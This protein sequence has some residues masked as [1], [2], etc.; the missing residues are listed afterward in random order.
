[1]ILL[2]VL[3]HNTVDLLLA[4]IHHNTDTF[5]IFLTIV[6]MNFTAFFRWAQIT[7]VSI[8]DIFGFDFFGRFLTVNLDQVEHEGLFKWLKRAI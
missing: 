7:T 5:N 6:K 3:I 2:L 4:G 8:H 1:M